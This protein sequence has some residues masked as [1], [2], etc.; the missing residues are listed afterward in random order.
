[1]DLGKSVFKFRQ[2]GLY[3]LS[4][5]YKFEQEGFETRSEIG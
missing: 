5:N 4:F 3:K 1:M 2:L